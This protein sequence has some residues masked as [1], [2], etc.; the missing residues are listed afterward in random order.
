M[1]WYWGATAN[2]VAQRLQGSNLDIT[3]YAIGATTGTARIEAIMDRAKESI[4]GKITDQKTLNAL[5]WGRFD[6]HQVIYQCQNTSQTAVDPGQAFPGTVDTDTFR[7][8]QNAK[9]GPTDSGLASDGGANWGITANVL[10]VSVSKEL[11]DTFYASYNVDP[12]TITSDQLAALV[13]D[14]TAVKLGTEEVFGGSGDDGGISDFVES[15]IVPS[16]NQGLLDL[17]ENTSIAKLLKLNMCEPFSNPNQ[18]TI[19]ETKRC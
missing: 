6:C 11:G 18:A 16:V 2:D 14:W 5:N 9:L 19:I 17:Q 1:G 15:T 3:V 13:I 8:E 10:T 7:I 4:L 12:D